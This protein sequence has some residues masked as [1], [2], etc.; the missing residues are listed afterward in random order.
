MGLEHGEVSFADI[1][2]LRLMEVFGYKHF[3]FSDGI[4]RKH[5]KEAIR[6]WEEYTKAA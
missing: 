3:M 1:A 4:S 6:L 2:D 5:F